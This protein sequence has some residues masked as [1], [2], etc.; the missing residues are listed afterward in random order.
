MP[1]PDQIETTIKSY[2][3]ALTNR[4][5]DAFLNCFADDAVQIDPYP[6]A[7]N[8]GRDAI[9]GF[10]DQ[11]IGMAEALQFDIKEQVI[12]GDRAAVTWHITITA[13]G[14]KLQIKGVDIFTFDDN[15]QIGELTAYWDPSKI[16][17]VS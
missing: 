16:T 9:G 14:N 3:A 10:W 15:G 6:N 17:P 11:Q 4:D 12:A 5:K 7:A 13:P 1:T 8:K 2:V